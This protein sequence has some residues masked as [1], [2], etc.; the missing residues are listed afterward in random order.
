[1]GRDEKVGERRGGR[2]D[3]EEC[4]EE[5]KETKYGWIRS[6]L[7]DYERTT[8]EGRILYM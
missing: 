6:I 1:M 8:L 3:C 2:V 4:C 7:E 5:E